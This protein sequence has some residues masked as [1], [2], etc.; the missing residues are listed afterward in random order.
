NS[1]D[2]VKNIL[3]PIFKKFTSVLICDEPGESHLQSDPRELPNGRLI[4]EEKL[5]FQPWQLNEIFHLCSNIKS[6][7]LAIKLN[8]S[9]SPKFFPT[10]TDGTGNSCPLFGNL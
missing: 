5:Y 1:N 10:E 2:R 8:G 6:V 4:P 9:K 7:V 3:L